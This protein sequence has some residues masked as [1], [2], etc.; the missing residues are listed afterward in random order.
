VED[1]L[2]RV[3][4]LA[5][6][7]RERQERKEKGKERAVEWEARLV[8]VDALG[9]GIGSGLPRIE[10]NL[11]ES[12]AEESIRGI[13]VGGRRGTPLPPR[14]ADSEGVDGEGSISGEESVGVDAKEEGEIKEKEVEGTV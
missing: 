2:P 8:N 14:T 4:A 3:R 9:I 5:A 12:V 11:A 1:I 10:I 7:Q 6:E 13:E